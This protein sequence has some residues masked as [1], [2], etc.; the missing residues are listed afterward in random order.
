MG[1]LLGTLAA[2][3]VRA[4]VEPLGDRHIGQADAIEPAQVI[5]P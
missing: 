2:H 5:E 4:T 3:K 1:E